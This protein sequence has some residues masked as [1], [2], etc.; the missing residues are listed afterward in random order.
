MSNSP[1]H[2]GEIVVQKRVGEDM[3]AQSNG[4]LLRDEIPGGALKFID[5]QPMVIVS[6]MDKDENIWASIFL[7]KAGFVKAPDEKN[8]V[9]SVPSLISGNSDIFWENIISHSKVGML[10]IELSRRR[11]LRVNGTV[12]RDND[13]LHLHVDQAYPNC[14]KYIQRREM[15]VS[16]NTKIDNNL[17]KT[18]AALNAGL[19]E[20]ITNSDMFFVGSANGDNDMDVSHRGGNPGFVQIIDDTTLKIP[21]YQGNSMFNTL[22]NFTVN[23]NAGLLFLDFRSGKTLQLTGK[24]DI[25][26]KE[27][28]SENITGG[29]RRFW[30]FFIS[31]WIQTDSLKDVKW[32]FIDYSPYNP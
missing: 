7:G 18:G 20:L 8:V 2:S 27:N 30:S 5:N 28:N 26:W 32:N 3:I 12:Q 23:P 22:G 11:R 4:Q 6:S 19:K 31:E 25:I 29:T 1:F 24:A 17:K 15:D 21:D 14:P 16:L 9:V 10:F 13:T